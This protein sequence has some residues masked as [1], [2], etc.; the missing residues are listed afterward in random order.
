MILRSI[1][2]VSGLC[3]AGP[4]RLMSHGK[5][6]MMI[7]LP[8]SYP[9]PIYIRTTKHL[10]C[11]PPA[12]PPQQPA[13]AAD[14][15]PTKAAHTNTE[16]HNCCTQKRGRTRSRRRGPPQPMWPIIGPPKLAP[17]GGPGL[18][19][20]RRGLAVTQDNIVSLR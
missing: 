10:T 14:P 16:R 8:L 17:E 20:A 11:P 6:K 19:W 1:T 12:S 4:Y 3:P 9:I 15:K 7:S 13:A 2:Y 5:S 18:G